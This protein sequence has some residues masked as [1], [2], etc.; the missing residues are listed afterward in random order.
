MCYLSPTVTKCITKGSQ[1]NSLFIYSYTGKVCRD[2]QEID[3]D[4]SAAPFTGAFITIVQF[5]RWKC[6]DICSKPALKNHVKSICLQISQNIPDRYDDNTIKT[7]SE[8]EDETSVEFEIEE[9]RIFSQGFKR[10]VGMC[11]ASPQVTKCIT[12]GADENSV[13]VYSYSHNVCHQP[14]QIDYDFSTTP[15]TDRMDIELSKSTSSTPTDKGKRDSAITKPIPL[16]SSSDSETPKV[17]KKEGKSKEIPLSSSP[18]VSIP[19]TKKQKGLIC[20][21]LD[22]IKGWFRR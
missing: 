6:S 2:P 3:Y 20:S 14:K 13:F 4:F 15:L 11:Y 9:G 8:C 7:K 19:M 22:W 18:V 10:N 17:M 12:K 21:M 16:S 5:Q 1:Q